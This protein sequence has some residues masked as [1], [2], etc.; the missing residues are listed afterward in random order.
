MPFNKTAW[1]A[2]GNDDGSNTV[3]TLIDKTQLSTLMAPVIQTTTSTG[4]QNNFAITAD[5][6]LLRCNNASL[7]TI[8]GMTAGYDGQE[9]MITNV[10]AGLVSLPHQNASSTAANRF[11]N[12]A[13]SGAT[14]LSPASGRARYVYDATSVAW[15]LLEHDQGAFITPTYAGTD[16]TSPTGT[17]V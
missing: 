7:L 13:T 17:W 2:L 8:T 15:V 9:V 1:T 4:T 11:F 14:S 5:T 12:I 10:G 16:Y 3:G 6:R